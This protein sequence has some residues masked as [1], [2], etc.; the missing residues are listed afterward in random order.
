MERIDYEHYVGV[1]SL[2]SRKT[3]TKHSKRSAAWQQLPLEKLSPVQHRPCR[4]RDHV[5]LKAQEDC[6]ARR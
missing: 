3:P 6:T 2:V 5:V 1:C 4:G